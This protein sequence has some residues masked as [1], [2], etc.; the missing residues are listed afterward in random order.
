MTEVQMNHK[1]FNV[2][3]V[4]YDES[5]GIIDSFQLLQ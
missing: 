5:T 4:L 1:G 2:E 3:V